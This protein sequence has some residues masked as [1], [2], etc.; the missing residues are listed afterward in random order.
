MRALHASGRQHDALTAYQRAAGCSARSSGSSPVTS[1]A[2]SSGGSSS[3]TR[4]SSGRA[5]VPLF[6]P[7]FATTRR[8]SAASTSSDGSVRRGRALAPASVRFAPCSGRPVP[9]VPGSSPSWPPRSSPTEA[10]SS[11]SPVR[12]ACT[13]SQMERT[14]LDHRRRRRPLPG[15][16]APA[17]RR[18]RGMDAARASTRSVRWWSQPSD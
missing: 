14:G 3:R 15:G 13:S 4:R 10:R 1:C 11:T 12:A 6:R 2:T 9:G 16:A 17:R 7:R 18:R 8:W 5:I